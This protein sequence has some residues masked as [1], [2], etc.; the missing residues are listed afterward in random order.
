MA[1]AETYTPRLK[2]RYDNE[3]RPQLKDDLGVK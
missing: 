3:I 1:T 2:E